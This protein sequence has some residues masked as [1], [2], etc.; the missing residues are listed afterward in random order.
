MNQIIRCEESHQKFEDIKHINEEENIHVGMLQHAMSTISEQ[1][2]DI[3]KGVEE[4]EQI[5]NGEE[6]VEE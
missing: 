6:P 1:A 4:A 5:I 3:N 2:K